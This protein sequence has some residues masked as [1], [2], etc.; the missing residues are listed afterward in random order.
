MVDWLLRRPEPLALDYQR[1]AH[2]TELAAW[3]RRWHALAS[4]DV[5]LT[6]S[7]TATAT[8]GTVRQR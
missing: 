5:A 1:R 7:G 8:A 2:E 4:A 3:L 6:A